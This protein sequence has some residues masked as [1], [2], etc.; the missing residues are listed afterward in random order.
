MKALATL[1]LA[2]EFQKPQL[3]L[4]SVFDCID[5]HT[6]Y[7]IIIINIDTIK[8]KRIDIDLQL[9]NLVMLSSYILP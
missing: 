2:Q 6:S 7:F 3:K 8:I 5:L 9:A 1:L 4:K